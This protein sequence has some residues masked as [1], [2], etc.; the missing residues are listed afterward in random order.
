V[1]GAAARLELSVRRALGNL[2]AVFGSH[3]PESSS[4]LGK[5]SVPMVSTAEARDAPTT[6]PSKPDSG[7]TLVIVLVALVSLAGLLTSL[8][9]LSRDA[10][11]TARVIERQVVARVTEASVF[12]RLKAALADQADSFETTLSVPGAA[13]ATEFSGHK[14]TLSLEREGGKID[15]RVTDPAIFARYLSNAVLA[16][17]PDI[18]ARLRAASA[19]KDVRIA[20]LSTL[21]P[22]LSFEEIAR[23]F[24]LWGEA[25]GIDPAGAS[26]AVL[27]ALPDLTLAG[28]QQIYQSHGADAGGA[29]ANSAYFGPP[30]RRFSLR[31]AI[32]WNASETWVRRIPFEITASG[33][34]VRL[35]GAL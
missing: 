6:P 29:F 4:E 32:D 5:G 14:V 28:A 19:S 9:L 15:P 3:S 34:P 7:F 22:H 24:T 21:L 17:P 12:A 35:A 13:I 27:S 26:L 18:P 23:D 30:S 11:L 33:Q 1:D 16:S 10:T 2:L 20:L 31:I 25:P 8:M